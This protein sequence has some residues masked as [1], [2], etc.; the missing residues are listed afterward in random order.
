MPEIGLGNG[1][2]LGKSSRTINANAEGVG[3]EVPSAGQAVP[4]MPTG[5][6]AFHGHEIALAPAFDVSTELM[7]HADEFVP[8]S[9]RHRDRFLR[10]GVPI[11]DMDISA[12]DRGL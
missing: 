4:A 12:A 1:H 11:I 5:D 9:H 3:T 8:D 2:E 7:N 6:V 10:P